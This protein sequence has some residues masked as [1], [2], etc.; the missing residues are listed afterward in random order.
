MLTK[1]VK[2]T[3]LN[4]NCAVNI[5]HYVS[6]LLQ[7]GVLGTSPPNVTLIATAHVS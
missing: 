4:F 1:Q 7:K 3:R 6:A 5:A 2:T